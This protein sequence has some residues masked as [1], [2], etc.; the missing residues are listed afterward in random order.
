MDSPSRSHSAWL[1]AG[2][3]CDHPADQCRVVPAEASQSGEQVGSADLAAV[4]RQP[5][6]A[7]RPQNLDR[8]G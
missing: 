2:K 6:T 8:P 4:L 3:R 5:F 1:V 7:P